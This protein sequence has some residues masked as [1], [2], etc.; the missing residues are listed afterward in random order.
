MSEDM[1]LYN[2]HTVLEDF[3]GTLTVS[4]TGRCRRAFSRST[5]RRT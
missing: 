3:S 4:C 1:L 2:T 5:E